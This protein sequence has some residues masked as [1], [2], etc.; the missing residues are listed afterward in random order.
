LEVA[1]YIVLNPVRAQM[2]INPGAWPWSNYRATAGFCDSPHW[3]TMDC[4]LSS[5]S[6]LR[7]AAVDAYGLCS[8][9]KKS[10]KM[11]K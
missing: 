8:G 10:T 2:V 1:R 3:L 9:E 5:F 6:P 4:L 11:W 7:V